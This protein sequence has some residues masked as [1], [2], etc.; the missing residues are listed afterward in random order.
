[1]MPGKKDFVSVL[2]A[3]GKS[4]STKETTALHAYSEFKVHH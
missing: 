1:M 4:P 2:G 3:D